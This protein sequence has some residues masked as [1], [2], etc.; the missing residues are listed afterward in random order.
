M[1]NIFIQCSKKGYQFFKVKEQLGDDRSS[2]EIARPR[3]FAIVKSKRMTHLRSSLFR[4]SELP[5]K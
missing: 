4:A 2:V 3:K 1:F 5:G